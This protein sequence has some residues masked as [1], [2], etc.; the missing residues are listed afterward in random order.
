MSVWKL[1]LMVDFV[2]SLLLLK[3]QVPLKSSSSIWYSAVVACVPSLLTIPCW[4]AQLGREGSTMCRVKEEDQ[5]EVF[6][7]EFA[8][9]VLS[10][11]SWHPLP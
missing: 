3:S 2:F 8:F 9:L 11:H 5:M 4:G 7:A 10:L 1:L 6:S